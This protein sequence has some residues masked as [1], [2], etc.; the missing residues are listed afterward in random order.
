MARKRK[1]FASRGAAQRAGLIAALVAVGLAA[2]GALGVLAVGR[3]LRGEAI[4]P[5]S[6]AGLSSNPDAL[7]ADKGVSTPPCH[8]CA[9]SYGVEARLRAARERRSSDAF[10][11]LGTV[12]ID[13]APADQPHDDY[14]YGGRFPDTAP[15]EPAVP[16]M[17]LP[18]AM[19]EPPVRAPP[20][21]QQGSGPQPDPTPPPE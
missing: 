4:A 14:R 21:Q 11:E 18:V 3:G 13:D 20:E 10:R 2:G 8:S 6:F 17:V 1:P 19:P 16:A 15:T 5:P 7:T 9:D 12:D